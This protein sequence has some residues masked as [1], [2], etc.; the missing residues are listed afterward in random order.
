LTFVVGDRRL[1]VRPG[2]RSV[3]PWPTDSGWYDFTVSVVEEPVFLRR[4]A[5]HVENGEESV[6]G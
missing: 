3:L 4:L 1:A 6:S 2:Q 5:G